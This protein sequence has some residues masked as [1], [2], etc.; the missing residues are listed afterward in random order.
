MKIIER[1]CKQTII[2]I[3]IKIANIISLPSGSLDLLSAKFKRNLN[4]SQTCFPV[5][6]PMMFSRGT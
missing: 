4:G 1:I 5:N 3:Y 6:I 2:L